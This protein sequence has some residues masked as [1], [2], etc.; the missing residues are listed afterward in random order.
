MHDTR[1]CFIINLHFEGLK[2]IDTGKDT[3]SIS[4]VSDTVSIS[5]VSD[6]VSASTYDSLPLNDK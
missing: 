4:A 6:T 5:A 2:G 1:R 3:V